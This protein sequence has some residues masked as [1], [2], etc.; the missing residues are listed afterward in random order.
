MGQSALMGMPSGGLPGSN[1]AWL[2]PQ[3]QQQQQQQFLQQQQQQFLQQQQQFLLQQQQQQQPQQQQLPPPTSVA[4]APC[5]AG[6][7]GDNEGAMAARQLASALI[8]PGVDT[9]LDCERGVG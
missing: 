1:A 3:Q 9:N 6:I 2:P 8:V 4:C 5:S 7:G